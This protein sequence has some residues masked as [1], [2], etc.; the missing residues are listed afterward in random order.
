MPERLTQIDVEGM[1]ECLRPHFGLVEKTVE[2]NAKKTAFQAALLTAS[3]SQL[4]PY[5]KGESWG[6][7]NAR[8]EI[9]IPPQYDSATLFDRNPRFSYSFSIVSTGGLKGVIDVE[10]EFVIRCTCSSGLHLAACLK[11]FF[12]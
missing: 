1:S 6:F 4:V 2:S 12:P 10:G 3:E 5:R 7:S 8:G 11:M 9:M